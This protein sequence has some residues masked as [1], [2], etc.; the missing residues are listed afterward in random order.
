MA[1]NVQP[2][3]KSGAL[4]GGAQFTDGD[5]STKK[6]IC[7]A[8]TNGTRIDGLL[9]SSN[10]TAAIDLEFY[11]YDGTTYHYI[12]YVN[13]PIGAGYP[14]VARVDGI[15]TLA[16]TNLKYIDF[17]SG[18]ALYAACAATMTTAKTCDVVPQ[19]GNY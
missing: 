2:I 9:I 10:D 11:I 5:A 18:S 6:L 8:G 12:G 4:G 15:V 3:F 16:P 1:A 13:V 14:S 19:G 7:T 17:P